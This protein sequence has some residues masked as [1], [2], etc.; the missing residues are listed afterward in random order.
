MSSRSGIDRT[1]VGVGAGLGA[2]AY[3]LGYLLTYLTQRGSVD[4][5]LET[6]NFLAELFGGDP[7][8]SWQGVG[9]LFYNAHFVDTEVPAFGGTR[10]EN[11]IAAGDGL[12]L[13]YLV[14]PLALLAA[15]A[16]AASV[17]RAERPDVGATA[18]ALV[19]VGYLPLAVVGAV[20][21]GYAVGEGTIRPDPVT[22]VLLA[23]VVYPVVLG[24]I[25]GAL[26]GWR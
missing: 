14:P 17:A 1:T 6:F 19:A 13:L 22:A 8:P 15:G 2:A 5:R 11:F 24:A 21:F 3:V 10:V 16:V 18:G 9:W 23:G 12:S 4:E 26:A 25:G 20:A 7:I